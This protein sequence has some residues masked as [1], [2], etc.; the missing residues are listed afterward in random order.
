M[1]FR[2]LKTRTSKKKFLG[3]MIII[4]FVA[5]ISLLVTRYIVIS[6]ADLERVALVALI[7]IAI[8]LILI[9]TR[10]KIKNKSAVRRKPRKKSSRKTVKR[11]VKKRRR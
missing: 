5:G 11:K 9:G 6:G 3:A 7:L 2:N 10:K 4:A 8:M 1:M